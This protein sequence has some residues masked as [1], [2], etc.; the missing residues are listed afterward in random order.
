MSWA[1]TCRRAS[2]F[3]PEPIH[4]RARAIVCEA[5]LDTP[6]EIADALPERRDGRHRE[7]EPRLV[8]QGEAAP[9]RG[10]LPVDG[11]FGGPGLLA[12][13]DVPLE[14][15][16]GDPDRPLPPEVPRQMLGGGHR[17]WGPP[18]PGGGQAGKK[19]EEPVDTFRIG[20]PN[21]PLDSRRAGPTIF[22]ILIPS[23]RLFGL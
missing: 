20:A 3:L 2:G 18:G 9:E 14:V 21:F 17:I 23:E 11:G 16:G 7:E 15:S 19:R 10:Q 6:Q 1:T 4:D 12:P 22:Q 5:R 13:H 8:A